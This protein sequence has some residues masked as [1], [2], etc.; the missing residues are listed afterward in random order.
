MNDASTPGHTNDDESSKYP[1]IRPKDLGPA[2]HLAMDADDIEDF[3]EH[4]SNHE[5]HEKAHRSE[6]MEKL[7]GEARDAMDHS[8]DDTTS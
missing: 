2:E 6:R 1:Y 8:G 3:I 4:F 7:S 5:E